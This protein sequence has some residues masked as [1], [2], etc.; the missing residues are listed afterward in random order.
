MEK[1]SWPYEF[2]GAYWL[3][4][5]EE[6]AVLDVLRNGSLFRYYGL[7]APTKVDGYEATAR[8]FY[9]VKYALG[10]NSGTGALMTAM[11]ALGVGPGTEVILPAFLW[12]AT[13]GVVV[14]LNAIPVLCEVDDS[15]NM[16]PA[17]LEKKITPRTKLIVP[18]H[19]AGAPCDMEA[20]MA[21]AR[22]HN[23][24][25]LEDCAQCNGGEIKGKKVG[26]FG[27]MG[28]FSL[29]LNKNMTC[30]E[31]GL[32]ITNDEKLFTRAF[33]A[34]DMGLI[35]VGGRLAAPEPEAVLWGQ[36][37][38][39]T[40]LCGAVAG[41]QLKKLPKILANMRGSK[42]RIKG[43]LQGLTFRKIHDETGDTG[44]FLILILKDEAGAKKA[45]EQ[46]KEQGLHNA[47]RLADYGLHIYYNIPSLVNKIPVS[48]AGNPWNLQENISSNWTYN[49]GTCPA[50]DALFAR[51]ILIPIPS[52][53]TPDQEKAAA[54]I[55][56]NAICC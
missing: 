26:T 23:L 13:V 27:T 10:V 9:E 41:V 12:V 33:S 36:G 40:E 1:I 4:Q 35:R 45:V 14:Q 32:I 50:S 55:I 29:Q 54:E 6:N 22:K 51:S 42:K 48:P 56:K 7:N 49:K 30:G 19:M 17:D 43:M 5:E 18:I 15:L 52:C 24:A 44:P 21:V 25:V 16:N 8:D 11:T 3:D 53:L 38:R 20:I 37:R 31:G 2:P 34:H 47:F 28:I 39:M 46:M